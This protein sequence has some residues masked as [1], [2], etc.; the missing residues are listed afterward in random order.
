MRRAALHRVTPLVESLIDRDCSG[1]LK[2][3]YKLES[4]QPSGSFKDRGIGFMIQSLLEGGNVNK[5]FTSSG[6]NG[7]IFTI[8]SLHS[9]KA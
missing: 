4:L 5:I 2:V 7:T 1:P 6:G 8:R 9:L 3:F